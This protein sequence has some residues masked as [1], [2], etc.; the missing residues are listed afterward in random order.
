[1]ANGPSISLRPLPGRRSIGYKLREATYGVPTPYTG[2]ALLSYSVQPMLLPVQGC[3]HF[4]PGASKKVRFVVG[5]ACQQPKP[6]RSSGSFT[7]RPAI[8]RRAL[9][10]ALRFHNE[11]VEKSRL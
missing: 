6:Q 7:T 5:R 8:V 1:M 11:G 9:K 2:C 3:G 10:I 4:G